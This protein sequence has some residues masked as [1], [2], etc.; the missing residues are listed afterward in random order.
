M[1]FGDILNEDGRIVKGVN[2]TVD[3]GVNQIE[4]EAAKWGYD[5]TKDGFAPSLSTNGEEA[6]YTAKEWAIMEGGHS[7]EETKE[8]TKLFDFDKY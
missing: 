4:I 8:K 7:L 1:K 5:V 6:R 2:T 3:V